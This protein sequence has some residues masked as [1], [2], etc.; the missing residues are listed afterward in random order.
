MINVFCSIK[1]SKL[2]NIEKS[3]NIEPNFTT[4]W[5]A[6]L[7]SVAG[8]KWI[9][10]VNKQTLFSFIIMDVVKKD[11]HNLSLLFTEMLIKQLDRENILTSNFESYLREFD[12]I[13]NI[14]TTDNDRKIM[15]SLND[16]VY[17]TKACYED[18][19]NVEKARNYALLYIN[20]MPSKVL[21]YRTPREAMREHIKNY[22]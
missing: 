20:E 14:C 5:N 2:L 16:F 15:G 1:L 4:D 12:Q 9:I 22:G 13:A 21:K 10:F 19:K 6:H 8:K 7:F 17:H 18:N 11:L 3:I